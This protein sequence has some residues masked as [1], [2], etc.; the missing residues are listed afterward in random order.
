MNCNICHTSL[1]QAVYQ[2][3]SDK[4]LTSLCE[5]TDGKTQVWSC[6]HCGHIMTKQL[7][8]AKQYYSEDYKI[9][10]S[11]DDEDQIY[12]LNGDKIVYRTQHQ[13]S[14]LLGKI[15]LKPNARVLD[16]GC[17]KATMP[18]LLLAHQPSLQMHLFDVSEM[19]KS[20]WARFLSPDRW[21]IDQ[22]PLDWGGSFDLV[23]SYFALEHIDD[24]VSSIKAVAN[25]LKD[26]GTFYGIV[27]DT[28]GNVADFI[29]ID[30]VNHFTEA[31]LHYALTQAGLADIE[32]DNTAHRGA[33]VF[34]A[35]KQAPRTTAK[36]VVADA[37]HQA[38]KL[39][40]YW[41]G[42]T[43]HL[44]KEQTKWLGQAFAIY[45]SGFYGAYIAST[46]VNTD[47]LRCFL[48]ASPY[49]QGKTVLGLPVLEPQQL[50]ADVKVLYIGLNPVIARKTVAAMQWLQQRDIEIIYLD[51]AQ[52]A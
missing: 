28:V 1:E 48:D 7:L 44:Q 4:A 43:Q 11:H 51:G 45:G 22:T 8:D 33:L 19:Y 15:T 5:I 14:T 30:H 10:L 38:Q 20:H 42:L 17:A 52:D 12:E 21:A 46:L 3:Q 27:P 31:S 13:L 41:S 9:L 49:Q 2:S 29:V 40:L 36:Q 6:H 32:I 25:L 37:L 50:P 24:S 18:K 16:Y 39:A 26:G 47:Q 23:T 34:V 35:R